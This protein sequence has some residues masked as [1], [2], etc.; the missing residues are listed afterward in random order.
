MRAAGRLR[1]SVLLILLSG[2]DVLPLRC[3][4]VVSLP[5]DLCM[6]Q[7]VRGNT[8]LQGA[9]DLA[10]KVL[11]DIEA[12]EQALQRQAIGAVSFS[13]LVAR[14]LLLSCLHECEMKFSPRS[15]P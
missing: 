11:Q 8:A 4:Q 2:A 13:A 3:L 10:L 9:L 6:Q 14:E 1:H 7:A 15:S 5:I 12:F